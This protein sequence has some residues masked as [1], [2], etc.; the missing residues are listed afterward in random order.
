MSS[1][2]AALTHRY[3]GNNVRTSTAKKR[4]FS[5]L[6]LLCANVPTIP[7]LCQ[8]ATIAATEEHA[9]IISRAV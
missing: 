8:T 3:V 5:F 6:D 9:R 4:T 2:A 1:D 7:V